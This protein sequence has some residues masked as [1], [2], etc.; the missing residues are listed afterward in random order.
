MRFG[1]GPRG[2]HGLGIGMWGWGRAVRRL[3]AMAGA[4]TTMLALTLWGAS[5]ASAGGPPPPHPFVPDLAMIVA[6]GTGRTTVLRTGQESFA[7]L[8]QLLR[9]DYTGTQR[10][11]EA[12]AEGRYPPVDFTVFWELTGIGGWPQTDRRAKVWS[13]P[14]SC[15]CGN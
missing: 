14:I 8:R 5:S 3:T 15:R 9:P 10:V 4:L 2:T 11:P 12:W 13:L 1:D 6:G 7:H